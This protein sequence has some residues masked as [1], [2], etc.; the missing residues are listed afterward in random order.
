MPSI[1]I[2]GMAKVAGL[3]LA[4]GLAISAGTALAADA[5]MRMTTTWTS[6]INLMEGDKKFVEIANAITGDALKIE[7]F[8]GGTLVPPTQVFDA[9]QSNTVQASADWP[10]YWAGK[11]SA[12]GL[13]GSYPM[14]FTAADYILWTKQWGGFEAFQEAYG[15]FGMVYLPYAVVSMESGLRGRNPIPTLADMEGKRI[16]MSGRAQGEILKRLG[17]AQTQIA[18]GEVYQA[19]E[20][21]V[22]DA[23]EFSGPGV[24]WGMGLQEVSKYWMTPGWHQPGSM[25]GVMINKKFWD[26]LPKDVQTKL[27]I[28]ADATLSWS[29]AYYEHDAVEAVRK[30]KEA[31]TE[32][33]QLPAEDVAKLQEISNQAL[34]DEACANPLFAKIAASQVEYMADY[35]EWRGMAGDFAMG[36]NLSKLPDVAKLKSCAG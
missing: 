5:T 32:V 18:G 11:N 6:G 1:T 3:T 25:S 28:A 36:R 31:G 8:E 15:Q 26:G 4:A 21:G 27:K 23:A 16:R 24:D 35:A 34:V 9:V 33:V 19:L 10:G 22:V 30:F 14:L 13:L 2:S 12:F 29:I 7:F 17:A 20:R